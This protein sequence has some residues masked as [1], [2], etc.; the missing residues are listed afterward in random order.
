MSPRVVF[1][2]NS[3][4]I[5]S[6]RHW[7]A[8]TKTGCQVVGVV[9][10]PPAKRSSTNTQK[11]AP[12]D[13]FVVMARRQGIARFEPASPNVPEFV[14]AMWELAPDL[15]IAVGYM[16]L[17]KPEVLTAPRIVAANFHASLLPAYRGKHPVFWALRNG[18]RWVGLTVHVMDPS[19]DTGDILYQVR[20]QTRRRDTVGSLYD[21]IMD[22][23]VPLVARLIGDV[24]RHNLRRIPQPQTGA[25][26]YSSVREQDLQLDW[27]RDAEVL[28][29]WIQTS[30]GQC[31]CQAGGRR[32]C[33]LDAEVTKDV[34][35]LPAGTLSRIG[36][37]SCVIT[38]GKDALRVRHV[39]VEG[40]EKPAPDL[41]GALGLKEGGSLG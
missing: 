34:A 13:N 7:G 19:L 23:S 36:R 20:V 41:F 26:Y 5:F 3:E 24:E 31:F 21:R 9:D 40:I 39:S 27:S 1:F 15:F 10:V 25:S 37:T 38:A 14:N 6:N 18:E 32:I 33:F 12:A 29:R 11:P 2:G 22:K 35:S 30:P 16:N 8:L 4:S 17:L 28:R